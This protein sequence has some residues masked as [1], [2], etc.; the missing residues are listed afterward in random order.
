MDREVLRTHS[1]VRSSSPQDPH[2]LRE[3]FIR[4]NQKYIGLLPIRGGG[5]PQPISFCFFPEE[6]FYCF[7][8]IYML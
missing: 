7:K 4:K 2:S 6:N 5:T 8:M 3:A 1:R